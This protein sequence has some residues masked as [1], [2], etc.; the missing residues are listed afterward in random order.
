LAP[1]LDGMAD[2][3]TPPSTEDSQ[4]IIVPTALATVSVVPLP[5]QTA[6]GWALAVPPTLARTNVTVA[7]LEKAA[8]QSP[9]CTTARNFVGALNG[10]V[11]SGLRRSKERPTSLRRH[12]WRI[13]NG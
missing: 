4:R 7:S 5:L 2:Q 9:L 12:Q 1:A 13:P 6:A 11:T 3:L 10:P 8:A